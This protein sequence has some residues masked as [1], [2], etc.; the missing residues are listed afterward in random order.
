MKIGIDIRTLLD[1]QYSGVPEYT[2]NLVKEILRQDRENQYKLFYNS[3]RDA[4]ERIPAFGAPNAEVVH[5]RYPNKIFNNIMQRIIGA[6]RIDRLLG[7]DLFFMPNLGFVSLS[8]NCRKIITIHDLSFMRYPEFYSF[9]RRL[10]HKLMRVAEILRK[11][12]QIVAVSENTKRDIVELMG[13]QAEKIKV[14]H[15]GITAGFGP[16]SDRKKLEEI[17]RK[18][19]LPDKFILALSTIEPRKNIE[20]IILAF[21]RC[22]R[23]RTI[24]DDC[25]LVIAGARGWKSAPVYKTWRRAACRDRIKFVGYV[26]ATDKPYLYNS[27][28]LFVYPSFYEGFGFPPLE[29]LACGCPVIASNAASLP[30][31]TDCMAV[32]VNPCDI[33]EI[34]AAMAERLRQPRAASAEDYAQAVLSKYSWQTAARNYI[35]LFNGRG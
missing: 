3:G 10:W 1:A 34:A 8:P 12:D 26:D 33:G 21:D 5:T 22:V 18:Y 30:E 7:V 29:A 25:A 20:G 15:N 23:E 31:I 28:S 32:M 4:S 16:I 14:I 6:P 24:G 27:A 35:E 9:K 2:Y 13:V 17:R 11:F 19:D